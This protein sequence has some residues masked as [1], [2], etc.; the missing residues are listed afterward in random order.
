[1]VVGR[2]GE[3]IV[4]TITQIAMTANITSAQLTGIGA[5]KEVDL[6]YFDTEIKPRYI[7]AYILIHKLKRRIIHAYILRHTMFNH[8]EPYTQN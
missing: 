7:H 5:L 8:N 4:D 6:G 1:M 3:E 2:I